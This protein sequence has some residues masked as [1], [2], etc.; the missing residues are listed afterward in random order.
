M[1]T[2][3]LLNCVQSNVLHTERNVHS[4]WSFWR[5]HLF[6]LLLCYCVHICLNP[7]VKYVKSHSWLKQYQFQTWRHIGDDHSHQT[8]QFKFFFFPF[9]IR[10]Q[11]KLA[12]LL[13]LYLTN[14]SV[15]LRLPSKRHEALRRDSIDCAPITQQ[16]T[17]Y[18]DQGFAK[19]YTRCS[20]LRSAVDGMW[21]ALCEPGPQLINNSVSMLWAG[22]P[23][24]PNE[25]RAKHLSRWRSGLWKW[26]HPSYKIQKK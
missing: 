26:T 2:W 20:I 14:P 1:R 19:T 21:Y 22:W 15:W 9:L 16:A 8:T 24:G 3:L 10:T 13:L 25:G 4:K 5:A 18:T 12:A 7:K 17:V 23:P 11:C 6:F